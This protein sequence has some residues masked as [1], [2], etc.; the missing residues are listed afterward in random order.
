MRIG[1][2]TLKVF[3]ILAPPDT[4][5]ALQHTEPGSGAVSA[6]VYSGDSKTDELINISTIFFDFPPDMDA[7][8][9]KIKK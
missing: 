5:F 7:F 9:P 3:G 4:D 1:V 2:S 8:L 6:V